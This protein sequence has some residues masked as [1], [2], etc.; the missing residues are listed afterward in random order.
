M[1]RDEFQ[2]VKDLVQSDSR[3][4]LS[5]GALGQGKSYRVMTNSSGQ[6][7]LDPV[8]TIPERELWL[9]QSTEAL[10]AVRQGMEEVA[11]GEVVDA[12][13]FAEYADLDID[14]E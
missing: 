6:I 1:T 3:G 4:R 8:V 13:S 10:N 5:L 9:W 2:V 7:L 11:A 14:D 12:G